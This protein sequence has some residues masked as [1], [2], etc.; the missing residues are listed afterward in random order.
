MENMELSSEERELRMKQIRCDMYNRTR[1]EPKEVPCELCMNR[2]FFMRLRPNGYEYLVP[3]QC[4]NIHATRRSLEA[5]GMRELFER[6]DFPSFREHS[7]WAKTM[8]QKA[9]HWA[10]EGSG[11]LLLCGQPGTG[12]THLALAAC[13]YRLGRQNQRVEFLPWREFVKVQM[14]IDHPQR[15]SQMEKMKQAKLLY[16]DD[17]FKTAGDK[18]SNLGWEADIAFE[19]I[20]YRYNN[21]LDTV[22]T[23][24]RGTDELLGIDEAIGSR[25]LEMAGEHA[26][27]VEKGA[28]KNYRLRTN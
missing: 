27:T 17:L 8:K 23:T 24:E 1:E 25:I 20:N 22:I 7:P 28:G 13:G 18:K 5:S 6:H 9:L 15:A 3:C 26:V 11:W 16:I 14:D 10:K 12:K 4:Q 19:L 2:G 21:R